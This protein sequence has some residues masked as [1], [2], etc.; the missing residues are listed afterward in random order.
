MNELL[1]LRSPSINVCFRAII[2]GTFDKKDIEQAVEK[3]CIRHPVLHCSIEMDNDNNAWFVKNSSAGIECYKSNEM[4][5][6]TWYQKTDNVPFDFAKGPLVR[7]CIILG[8]NTEII[9]LGH[10]IIGDGIGYLNVVKDVLLALDSKID[11]TPQ[12]PP[13]EPADR[14]F[15]E[16]V[17]LDAP[18]KSYAAWLNEEWRK[19]RG[20]FSEEEYRIF[21]DEYRKK[22]V[23]T[24]FMASLEG[25]DA[26]KL[27]E[28]S[29]SNGLTVNEMIASAFSAALM[30]RLGNTELRLGIA[31]NIRR[32]LVSEP[33][34]CMGNYVTGI[35]AKI[36][37]ER[38]DSFIVNAKAIAAIAREQLTKVK[39]R[40]LVV[41]FLNEFDKDFIAA[42][43]FAA[44]GNFD[45]PAAKKLAELIGEQT[46][47]KGVGISNLGRHNF[48]NYENSK[49]IDIQF[50]GPAFPANLLTVGVITVNNKIN[51]CLRYNE[52]E[53]KTNS[54]KEIYKKAIGLLT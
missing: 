40:H 21:F 16:T 31:A 17:L 13:S 53:I 15:K 10:H 24:L 11:T 47:N 2:A 43:M 23:P 38:A 30:E 12:I 41:H 32:E 39:N 6:Q 49:V 33:N 29:K 46:E 22:Y 45:H 9:I 19:N 28:K 27:L 3:V 34:N 4:D 44:Y 35:S 52:G 48:N 14:Y 54:I 8:E 26:K 36:H 42:T 1:Y 25:D 5:W 37:Y 20:S 18:T 7:F 51:L 50:V